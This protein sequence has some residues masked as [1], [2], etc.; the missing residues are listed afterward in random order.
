MK[1]VIILLGP[2]GVGKT[3]ASIMLA[4][5]LDTEIISADSM[6]I[7]KGMDIGTAKPTR[8]ERASVKH[9]MIDVV[10]P[11]APFSAGQYVEAVTPII[12]SLLSRQKIP[13]I[14]GG[15]GLYIKALTRG[16]F[17]GPSADWAL[18]EELLAM[19]HDEKGTLYS[20]LLHLDP[21]AAEKI[22]SNDI[23]RIVRAIEVCLKS[24]EKMSLLQEKLTRPLP[25]EFIKIG[26]TR[27][28]QE[29]YSII[30]QRVD[31]MIE[32]GLIN[33]VEAILRMGPDRTPLQAIGY[34]EIAGYLQGT[35]SKEEAIRLVKR[36]SKRYAK[37]QF[38]WFRK[39]EGIRWID[40]T[41]VSSDREL[42]LLITAA[43][44]RET[45]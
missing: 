43:L 35:L 22:S 16:I 12:N 13:L 23:R 3:G 20:Y 19:E 1:K 21:Y 39:E 36:N 38:T 4:Q 40:A 17:S 2:T 10:S 26:L 6:Q 9:H 27:Q 25:F 7:Y 32:A 24:H 34:K 15:T 41:G 30:E 18:R 45:P 5:H 11:S 44:M 37:R 31:S 8:Q 28:R 33:E 14:V 29:L 42:Y